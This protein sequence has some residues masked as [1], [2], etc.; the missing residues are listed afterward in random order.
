MHKKHKRRFHDRAYV[1]KVKLDERGLPSTIHL[2]GPE[3]FCGAEMFT[4]GRGRGC[5]YGHAF[6]AFGMLDAGIVQKDWPKKELRSPVTTPA[7]SLGQ[8]VIRDMIGDRKYKKIALRDNGL[9]DHK[10]LADHFDDLMARAPKLTAKM[11]AQSWRRVVNTEYD[12]R[13]SEPD[14]DPFL[15]FR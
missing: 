7:C 10:A 14:W 15:K 6:Y 9:I 3:Q 2:P 8:A 13:V 5:V 1:R 12:V 4:D 11:A